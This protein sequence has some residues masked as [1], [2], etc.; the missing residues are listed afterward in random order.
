MYCSNCG[1]KVQKENEVPEENIL[2]NK[3]EIK[4]KQKGKVKF[5][6]GIVILGIMGFI[7]IEVSGNKINPVS[8][9]K[10]ENIDISLY[11]P[12]Q[13]GTK[14]YYKLGGETG[15]QSYN[16]EYYIENFTVPEFSQEVVNN[17]NPIYASVMRAMVN[18][19]LPE[20]LNS[21]EFFE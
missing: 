8:K 16:G 12:Q 14:K 15:E 17:E 10:L 2:E 11:F 3:N 18:Q 9:D 1:D 5:I 4:N 20:I 21:I 13:V 19:D 7:Y 6:V